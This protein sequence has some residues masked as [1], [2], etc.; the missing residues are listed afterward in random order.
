LSICP[1]KWSK[2]TAP[3]GTVPLWL[4]LHGGG[5]DPRQFVDEIGL[6]RWPV[7][8]GSPWWRRIT[9]NIANLLSDVLPKL[10]KYMLKTYPALDASRVYVTGY[11]MG[12]AATLRAINGDPS[13]FAAAVPMA[14]APTPARRNRWRSSRRLTCR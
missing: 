3:A 8:S 13:V 7:P 5:D 4:A 10:V 6:L 9:Q 11:S 12:G 1:T 14:A 2:G